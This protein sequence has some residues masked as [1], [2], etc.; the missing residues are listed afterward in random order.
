MPPLFQPEPYTARSA[1]KFDDLV[2][3]FL[4]FLYDVVEFLSCYFSTKFVMDRVDY[5]VPW[6]RVTH[7]FNLDAFGANPLKNPPK[8]RGVTNLVITKL[9]SNIILKNN[10]LN[11]A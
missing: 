1:Q 2:F 10:L 11:Y 7:N 8:S 4:L 3:S 5:C 6:V 9:E